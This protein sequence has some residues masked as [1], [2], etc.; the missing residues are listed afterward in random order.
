MR[1]VQSEFYCE[2]SDA[3]VLKLFLRTLHYLY[4]IPGTDFL[5]VGIFLVFFERMLSPK[6]QSGNI[7]EKFGPKRIYTDFY[8]ME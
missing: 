8:L 6:H 5:L 4:E 2:S 1:S 3:R 7:N